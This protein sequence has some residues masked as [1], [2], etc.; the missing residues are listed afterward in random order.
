MFISDKEYKF[1]ELFSVVGKRTGAH[2]PTCDL[3][4]ANFELN[5]DIEYNFEI[6]KIILNYFACATV[7]TCESSFLS[8][9][10]CVESKYRKF[11]KHWL[12]TIAEITKIDKMPGAVS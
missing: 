5:D 3:L 6:N 2:I 10:R 9:G 11:S 8:N 7:M 12:P 4:Y 1:S